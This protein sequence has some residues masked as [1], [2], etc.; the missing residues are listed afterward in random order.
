MFYVNVRLPSRDAIIHRANHAQVYVR[1]TSEKTGYWNDD[2]F[3][4]YQ[5]AEESGWANDKIREVRGCR[6]PRCFGT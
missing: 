4:T 5:D 6:Q 3:E 2:P 1:C